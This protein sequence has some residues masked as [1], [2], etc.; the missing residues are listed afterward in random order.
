MT[1]DYLN[2][3]I[4]L[5]RKIF[6]YYTDKMYDQ[7]SIG[8][9]NYKVWYRDG[10]QLYYLVSFDFKSNSLISFR[11]SLFKIILFESVSSN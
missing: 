11:L 2:T 3:E 5:S 7:L 10:L 4:Q 8:N 1:Q 6:M 9:S